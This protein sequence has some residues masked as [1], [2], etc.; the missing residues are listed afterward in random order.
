MEMWRFTVAVVTIEQLL[1]LADNAN[2]PDEY[3]TIQRSFDEDDSEIVI[4]QN[5]PLAKSLQ[6]IAILPA[7]FC[8]LNSGT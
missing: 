3:L 6:S 7:G 2:Q 5:V 8:S 1:G 4:A